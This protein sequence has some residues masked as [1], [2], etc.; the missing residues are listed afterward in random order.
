MDRPGLAEELKPMT[1]PHLLANG[2][3]VWTLS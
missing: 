1:D 2:P 3:S